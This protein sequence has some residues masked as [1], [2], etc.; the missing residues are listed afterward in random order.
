MSLWTP[1]RLLIGLFTISHNHLFR[2]V[3]FTHLTILHAN[4]IFPH[5]LHNTLQVKPSHFETLAANSLL[6]TVS[7]REL[8]VSGSCRELCTV[9]VKVT[10]RLTVSQSVSLGVE[11]HLRLMTRYLVLFDSY[12]LV[13]FLWGAYCY[14]S[15]SLMLRPTVSRPV[16]LGIKRPSGAYDQ[17]FI[18]VRNTSDSYVLVSVVRPL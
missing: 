9:K 6:K 11:P 16:C 17:I 5:S 10:L 18:S 15:L 14:L 7:C 13:F 2:C 4:I 12:G 8:S 1:F 3:T